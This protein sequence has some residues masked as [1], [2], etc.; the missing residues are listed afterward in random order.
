[1]S[2]PAHIICSFTARAIDRHHAHLAHVLQRALFHGLEGQLG[3][4]QTQQLILGHRLIF[5][6]QRLQCQSRIHA[7]LLTKLCCR[8]S[9]FNHSFDPPK[10]FLIFYDNF[11]H[12]FLIQRLLLLMQKYTE[13]VTSS[14]AE[15]DLL[16]WVV[17]PTVWCV[18]TLLPS[19]PQQLVEQAPI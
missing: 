16:T 5:F 10:L 13:L 6:G 2:F 1:M 17:S 8:Y 14:C 9:F 3:V 4:L 18:S 19:G 12:S 15:T 7:D 11:K